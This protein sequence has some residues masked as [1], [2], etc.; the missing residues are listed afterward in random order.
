MDRGAM[1]EPKIYPSQR[2][3]KAT[4]YLDYY[5][6]EESTVLQATGSG[7]AVTELHLQGQDI[8]KMVSRYLVV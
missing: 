7:E 2:V 8:N 4:G 3:Y 1:I 5:L 6:T